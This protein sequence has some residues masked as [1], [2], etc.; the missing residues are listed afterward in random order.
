MT[1]TGRQGGFTLIELLVTLA[2]VAVLLTVAVPSYQY[3]I[4]LNR[5]R[6]QTDDFVLGLMYAKSEAIKRG[7]SVSVCSSSDGASCTGSWSQGW[8][9][10]VDP[11]NNGAVDTGETVLRAHQALVGNNTLTSTSGD[12]FVSFRNTGFSPT[13]A[14]VTFK[15][16]DTSGLVD[17]KPIALS[18][19]GQVSTSGA[20]PSCP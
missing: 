14:T 1:G 10:F 4:Q 13:A 16:C 18:A 8:I 9:V 7:Q 17:G 12:A 6:S 19:Q 11:N 20:I 2:I 15:L 3:F 5:V